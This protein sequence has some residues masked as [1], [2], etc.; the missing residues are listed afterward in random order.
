MVAVYPVGPARDAE[1]VNVPV[2]VAASYETIPV[3]GVPPAVAATVKVL[4]VRLAGS[5]ASLNVTVIGLVTETPV[6]PDAG[7]VDTTLGGASSRVVKE[8]VKSA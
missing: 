3:T 2:F 6:A 5:I 7:D 8:T 1:G 4:A